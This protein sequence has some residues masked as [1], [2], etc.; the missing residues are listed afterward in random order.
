[1][2]GRFLLRYGIVAA[3]VVLASVPAHAATRV[4]AT[5]N[6]SGTVT[7]VAPISIS[8]LYDLDFGALVVTSAGTAVMD[9]NTNQLTTT[10]GVT[11]T[12]SSPHPA[13]FE[14]VAP[15]KSKVLIKAPNRP[16]TLTRVGG[17][18]TMTISSFVIS[19]SAS[20]NVNSGEPIAFSVG[21]TLNVNAGQVEGLYSGNF[22]VT[23]NY[24]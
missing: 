15:I 10:G 11:L 17:T 20:R 12:S 16:I 21:G 14:T 6:A 13:Y 22:D 5:T 18:E 2:S 1:M 8:K 3:A 23:I 19:G 9:P 7:V 24:N 4:P